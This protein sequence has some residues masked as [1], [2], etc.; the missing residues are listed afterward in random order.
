MD[1][2]DAIK[3]PLRE[4]A[5]L[6]MTKEYKVLRQIQN[7]FDIECPNYV[8]ILKHTNDFYCQIPH[9][10]QQ[11]KV[12]YNQIVYKILEESKNDSNQIDETFKKLNID[13]QQLEHNSEKVKIN[14][15]FIQN[16]QGY[17]CKLEVEHVFELTKEQDDKRF[18]Q[19][20]GNRMLLY[21]GSPS[22]NFAG[23]QAQGLKIAALEAPVTAHRFGKGIYFTDVVEKAASYVA[24]IFKKIIYLFYFAMWHRV[25]QVSN[26]I[27]I[28]MEVISL[29][30]LIALWVK[31]DATLPNNL[32]LICLD[33]L[34]QKFQLV[35]LNLENFRIHPCQSAMNLQFMMMLKS[36]QSIQSN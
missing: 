28:V 17:S 36:G 2:Y 33:C 32:M 25:I 8:E 10:F 9:Y 7:E 24:Q 31:L 29:K 34:M 27:M 26:S 11:N 5:A 13:I 3:L 12:P 18:K 16:T 22:I 1:T 4:L 20:F 19:D 6:V 30:R 14:Q 35:S 21:L 23:I 15:M